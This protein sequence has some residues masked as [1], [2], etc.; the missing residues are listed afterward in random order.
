MHDALLSLLGCPRCGHAPL[1]TLESQYRC[2]PCNVQF[3]L[4]EGIPWLFAEP[5]ASLNEWQGRF[6]FTL[7]TLLAE[8]KQLSSAADADDIRNLTRR[9]LTSMA[10]A[11]G[12]QAAR[13]GKLL[14]P[15]ELGPTGTSYDTQLAFR[16]RLPA[17]QGL[18]TYAYN[19]FR[20]WSWG[21]EE[22]EAAID[23][24]LRSLGERQPRQ[25]LV[26]GAGSGRFAYDLH[27]RT[28]AEL[29][30]A[31]DF[32]PFLLLLA[33]QIVR[34]KPLALYE[35]PH[36]PRG[37]DDC[38]VLRELHAEQPSR[39]G[40]HF[41]LGDALRA[42]FVHGGFDSIVTPWLVDIL[43]ERFDSLCR[44]LNALLSTGGCWNNF[45]TLH[46]HTSD[47]RL[48]FTTEECLEIIAASGFEIIETS[49]TSVPYL[50]SPS[51]RHGRQE[52]VFGWS[53][54]KREDVKPPGTYESYPDWIVGGTLPVPLL[55]AFRQQADY[56]RVRAYYLSLIDGHRSI[57][58][59]ARVFVEHRL[60]SFEE[61]EAAIRTSLMKLYDSTR[62]A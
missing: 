7:Q 50:C 5:T 58:D 18:M 4:I 16:T 1:E 28:T 55:E 44:R 8:Q 62:R 29:T 20:D 45:G 3:P 17:D 40:L 24:V 9:R 54:I 41:V 31:F 48:Q 56:T 25:S 22:N 15:L 11:K 59:M 2:G 46:F 13:L 61:A 37:I 43:P 60:M 34:G 36:A 21:Q 33:Q 35:F 39:D 6:N 38:A 27:M 53:A 10:E 19:A 57:H 23:I 32:N 51:S 47:P 52:S 49:E 30:V 14:K 12:D 26:I 42:P